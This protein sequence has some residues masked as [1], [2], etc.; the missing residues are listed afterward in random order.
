MIR[1]ETFFDMPRKDLNQEIMEKKLRNLVE[2]LELTNDELLN[3][4][5][6]RSEHSLLAQE[7]LDERMKFELV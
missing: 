4:V 6:T 7:I 1:S 3:I 2:A 5:Q